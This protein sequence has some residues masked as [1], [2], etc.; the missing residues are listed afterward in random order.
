[1]TA[2]LFNWQ[3]LE[4]QCD[5]VLDEVLGDMDSF[6][7]GAG[8]H[9]KIEANPTPVPM[10]SSPSLRMPNWREWVLLTFAGTAASLAG[11][12]WVSQL[13]Q[14]WSTAT[15]ESPRNLEPVVPSPAAT[16]QK[17]LTEYK[18]SLAQTRALLVDKNTLGPSDPFSAPFVTE[19]NFRNRPTIARMRNLRDNWSAPTAPRYN[20]TIAYLPPPPNPVPMAPPNLKTLPALPAPMMN[21]LPATSTPVP[22]STTLV[23]VME[24]AQRTAVF[25][26]G[27]G[28][29]EFK[30]GDRL[31]SGWT[32]QD[33]QPTQTIMKKG[34]QIRTVNLGGN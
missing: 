21:S 30:V 2:G 31:N 5:R 29:K 16:E 8:A 17:V 3:D 28:I 20:P 19:R 27:E 23:G 18:S 33:I 14:L 22:E 7:Q 6:A 34:D 1:M 26:Q 32:I 10:V 25:Q 4:T 24:G 11:V 9:P 15:E 13:N 12:M